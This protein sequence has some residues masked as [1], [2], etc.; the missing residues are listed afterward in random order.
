MKNKIWSDH[1]RID[2]RSLAMDKVIARK[3]KKDPS[4]LCIAKEN[5]EN[6]RKQYE[7]LPGWWKEWERIL[8]WKL[9]RILTFLVSKS[10][11]ARRLRQSSPFVGILTNEERLAIYESFTIG[12]YYKSLR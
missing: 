8:S 11:R 7:E 12:A 9:D 6:W 2:E 1:I 10:D 5:L 3:I 4:L